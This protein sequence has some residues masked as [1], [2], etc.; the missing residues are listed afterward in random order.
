ML[1]VCHSFITEFVIKISYSL[2]ERFGPEDQGIRYQRFNQ[3]PESIDGIKQ[4]SPEVIM[5]NPYLD[6][7]RHEFETLL[8]QRAIDGE[9]V[10][11]NEVLRYLSSPDADE[12]QAVYDAIRDHDTAEIWRHLLRCLA[13][14]CWEDRRDSDLRINQEASQRID[15][16]ITEVFTKDEFDDEAH[17]K[18]LVLRNSLNEPQN[19]IRFAAIYL[20]GLRGE[21]DMLTPLVE[22]LNNAPKVWKVRAAYALGILGDANC[23]MPLIEALASDRGALHNEAKQA[24]ER[25]GDKAMTAWSEALNHPDR[26]IRWHAAH[27]L[28]DYTDPRSLEVLVEGLLDDN[29]EVRWITANALARIGASALPAMLK[30]LS[31]E[32]VNNPTRQAAMFALHGSLT[33]TNRPVLKPLMDALQN[34]MTSGEVPQIAAQLLEEV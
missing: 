10:A 3:S 14:W 4:V 30:L 11:I 34:P 32:P 25:F 6:H 29:S 22:M 2:M 7:V 12:R 16:S 19:E 24:L 9:A 5:V 8:I 17:M 27:S 21:K 13:L 18:E 15:H 28:G 23:A 31:R 20:L 1:Q 26:H 33:R